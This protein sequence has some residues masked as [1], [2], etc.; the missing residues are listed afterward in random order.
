[1]SIKRINEKQITSNEMWKQ[2]HF[3]AGDQGNSRS[4]EKRPRVIAVG[5]GKGG[6]GKTVVS[7][8]LGI[9]LSNMGKSTII[10][11]ADL[12]GGNLHGYLNILDPEM[13]LVHFLERETYNLND[14]ALET[15]FDNLK[16]IPVS[17][18][19]FSTMQMKY[20]EKQKLLRNIRKLDADYVILDLGAGTSFTTIDFYLNADDALLV[21]TCDPLSVYDAYGFIRASVFRQLL[22]T[23]RH[24]PEFLNELKLCGDLSKGKNVK[25]L[26][27]QLYELK[28]IPKSWKLLI[29]RRIEQLRPKIILNMVE[30]NDSHSEL[31]ALRLSV[32]ELLNVNLEHWG[33]I[34]MDH[35]VSGAV[36]NLRP[37][38]LLKANSAASEDIVRIV[39][40]NVIARELNAKKSNGYNWN[41]QDVGINR[42]QRQKYMRICNYRCIA[43]NCCKERNGGMPCS[44]VEPASLSVK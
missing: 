16:I 14:L 4:M 44:K 41:H 38:L 2:G 42:Y 10:L 35:N 13:T 29:E 28:N 27:S 24:W 18:G 25:S 15:A 26:H 1:M 8:M 6:V 36:R 40:R 33:N 32:K 22:R 39:N 12:T 5:G 37:D 21:A 30:K 17:Q 43:W 23:F 7:T 31:Q 9:C 34:R 20:W 19:H 11:D 3:L